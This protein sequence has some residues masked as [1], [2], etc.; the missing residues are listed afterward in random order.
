MRVCKSV[1]LMFMS[2]HQEKPVDHPGAVN[3]EASASS[4]ANPRMR[5][6]LVD[7]D[8]LIL[9]LCSSV[10]A[11]SGYLVDTAQDGEAAWK[12]LDAARYAP[13]SFDLLITD[14]NMPNVT[15]V[16]LVARLRSVSANMPVIMATGFPPG[17]AGYLN[18][19]AILAKPFTPDELLR[20]VGEVLQSSA[21]CRA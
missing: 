5:I 20:T 17:D 16:E 7:D 18:L 1:K 4:P 15:G 12:A 8:A 14:N 19:S 2:S 13:G 9:A 21:C 10:L 6:L 3:G 11:R